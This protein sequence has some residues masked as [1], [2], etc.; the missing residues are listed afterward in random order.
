MNEYEK[1]YHTLVIIIEPGALLSP[2]GGLRIPPS[3]EAC[4]MRGDDA[5]PRLGKSQGNNKVIKDDGSEISI[6]LRR[7]VPQRHSDPHY[8][9]YARRPPFLPL[10]MRTVYLGM[11]FPP[12]PTTTTTKLPVGHTKVCQTPQVQSMLRRYAYSQRVFRWQDPAVLCPPSTPDHAHI[13]GG[14]FF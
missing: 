1:F 11:Q 13:G 4:R 2:R 3:T 10:W 9:K 6:R 5:Q 12:P 14:F 7:L 8:Y